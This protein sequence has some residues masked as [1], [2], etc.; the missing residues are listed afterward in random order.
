MCS[1]YVRET[2]EI[3]RVFVAGYDG[4]GTD[5]DG[6]LVRTLWC[7]VGKNVKG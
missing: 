2:A 3:E 5:A 4:G 6:L 7:G 1:I